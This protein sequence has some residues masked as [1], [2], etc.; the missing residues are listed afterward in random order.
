[1][2]E[3][4]GLGTEYY[5]TST[6]VLVTTTERNPHGFPRLL[7][8]RGKSLIISLVVWP[9][10]PH[11]RSAVSYIYI[12]PSQFSFISIQDFTGLYLLY[13]IN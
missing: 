5:S 6:A 9:E 8:H 1:M 7:Y 11:Q 12:R 4:S 2:I 10:V 3:Y 13:G